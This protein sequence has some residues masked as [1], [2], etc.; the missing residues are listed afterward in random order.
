MHTATTRIAR[1]TA[2]DHLRRAAQAEREGVRVLVDHRTGQHVATSASDASRCYHVTPVGCT[3]RGFTY[4][5]RCKHHTLLL[6]E[7]GGIPDPDA[8]PSLVA[9]LSD[10]DVIALKADAMRRHA[11]HGEALVNVHTGEV[12]ETAA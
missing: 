7:L 11:L 1:Q 3:C 4:W 5:N 10:A 2:A 12:I 6:A 8:A 9:G